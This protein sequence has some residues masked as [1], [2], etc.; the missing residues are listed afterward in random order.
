MTREDRIGEVRAQLARR[1][2]DSA[3][4]RVRGE[5]AEMA[6]EGALGRTQ[7]TDEPHDA[8]MLVGE[9]QYPVVVLGPRARFDHHRLA[10]AVRG[11]DLLPITREHGAVEETALGRPR[12]ALSAGRVVEVRVRVDDARGRR[13]ARATDGEG[14]G[15]RRAGE[16]AQEGTAI[17]G[18]AHAGKMRPDRERAT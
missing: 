6:G 4:E 18:S 8:G 9:A 14:G 2:P 7:V 17:G 12:H 3:E 1:Y 15:A 5:A 10:D 13:P 16:G 11:G